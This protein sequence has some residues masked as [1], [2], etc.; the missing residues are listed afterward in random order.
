MNASPNVLGMGSA[1]LP[2]S[3]AASSSI[4]LSHEGREGA[5]TGI[6]NAL[7]WKRALDLTCLVLG[8]PG[9]LILML[10]I[11]MIIKCVSSG[12]IFFRQERVGYR[13]KGFICLKFRTMHVGC[14]TL[15]HQQYVDSLVQSDVPMTKLDERNDPRLI[16]FGRMLRATGLDELP[17]LIN[18]ARGEM[19]LVG[20]RPCTP[21]ELLSYRAWQYA[22]FETLPGLTGLWQVSGKNRTTFS[23]MIDLDVYYARNKSLWFDLKIMAATFTTLIQQVRGAYRRSSD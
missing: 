21:H 20:P 15:S 23:Q 18:V 4:E 5:V 3:K 17:Q 2:H 9:V 6:L 16:R 10:A 7:P 8:L 13:R 12:P 1:K 19:S 22:R 11:A 14:D